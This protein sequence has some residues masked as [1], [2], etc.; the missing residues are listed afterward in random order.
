MLFVECGDGAH[1]AQSLT[2][3]LWTV[4]H[5]FFAGMGGFAFDPLTEAISLKEEAKSRVALSTK[6]ILIL[7][8][9]GHIPEI[10]KEAIMDKSKADPIAKAL[11]CV[12]AGWCLLQ[13][14]G[15]LAG[16]LPVTLLELNTLGHAVCAL[17]IY[18]F[19]WHKPLDI[20]EPQVLSG[21]WMPSFY[22]W[23]WMASDI[24]EREIV[25]PR[26]AKTTYEF[27]YLSWVLE[28]EQKDIPQDQPVELS[29]SSRLFGFS[30]DDR[31]KKRRFGDEP[32]RQTVHLSIEG[33]RRWRLASVAKQIIDKPLSELSQLLKLTLF[34]RE[35]LIAY[36]EY[37]AP[38]I[39]D[40]SFGLIEPRTVVDELQS[41]LMLVMVGVVYGGLH[42]SAWNDFFPTLQEQMLW[43]ISSIAVMSFG[44]FTA[45]FCV[46]LI[47]YNK[48]KDEHL[49]RWIGTLI[50]QV[51]TATSGWGKGVD[52]IIYVFVM[53]LL[54]LSTLLYCSF[55]VFLIVG[56]FISLRQQPSGVYLTPSW[57]QLLPHL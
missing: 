35:N 50:S 46:S 56:S 8:R 43:R 32:A 36:G 49:L 2:P 1:E 57:S 37:L 24:G 48:Y 9:H 42:A 12:Q 17:L 5:G 14:I 34:L 31:T 38:Y 47:I 16:H 41:I 30:F 26:D 39:P 11:V 52:L 28:D 55:R 54:V 27:H 4:T 40:W 51:D 13:Y 19:W 10:S 18:I 44:T 23:M 25:F 6:A 29:K 20:K 3:E 22:A 53:G 21:E 15:R 45:S 33:V 7:A